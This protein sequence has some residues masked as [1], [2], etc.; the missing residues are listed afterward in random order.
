MQ[1]WLTAPLL[2]RIVDGHGVIHP[3]IWMLTGFYELTGT[4]CYE[5]RKDEQGASA[6][7]RSRAVAEL[8]GVR[9]GGSLDLGSGFSMIEQGVGLDT[10]HIWAAQYRR[11]DVK[12]LDAKAKQL[13]T[14]LSKQFRL[15]PDSTSRGPLRGE[16]PKRAEVKLQEDAEDPD[17]D[18][19]LN[20]AIEELYTVSKL[21]E[22]KAGERK[23]DE[24]TE[25][26]K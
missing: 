11:L 22:R 10:P 5:M 12:Y 3:K 7:A 24:P 20:R 4:R 1:V 9:L 8:T 19:D 23:L 14:K 2:D 17:Y 26:E 21:P 25:D 13:E 6:G 15:L 16:A 18:D